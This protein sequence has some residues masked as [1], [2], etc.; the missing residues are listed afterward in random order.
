[1]PRPLAVGDFNGDGNLDIATAEV[2][3]TFDQPPGLVAVLLGNGNGTF[4]SPVYYDGGPGLV[5]LA[6]GDVNGDGILDLVTVNFNNGIS[7]VN[8]LLGNGDGSFAIAQN[9]L[10]GQNRA[11]S[12]AVGAL[13]GSGFPDVAIAI[14]LTDSVSVLLNSAN[15][16]AAPGNNPLISPAPVAAGIVNS[17][18]AG[19]ELSHPSPG[20]AWQ[21]PSASA[22]GMAR[23]L[24]P[25]GLDQLPAPHSAIVQT[26]VM[27]STH[28][29]LRHLSA[30]PMN[31][32][33]KADGKDE[34]ENLW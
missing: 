18:P 31:V 13:T 10:V 20:L 34:N 8:V 15:W 22:D 27:N 14:S 23:A 3:S 9:L 24:N 6:A 33:E 5:S 4:E 7:S 30:A 11:S 32:W 16:P 2:P 12:L 17:S 28:P 19:L 25:E 1:L 21:P 26:T 29:W